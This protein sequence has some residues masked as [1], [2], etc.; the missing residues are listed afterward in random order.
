M[1]TYPTL[2]EDIRRVEEGFLKGTRDENLGVYSNIF[3]AKSTVQG[4]DG[5]MATALL[6]SGMQKGLF[7]AAIVVQRKDGYNAEAV[8]AENIDDIMKAKGTKYLR[9]RMM[10]T[11]GELIDKGKRKIAIVGTPCEVRAARRIQQMLLREFPTLQI[12]IIGL[13]CFEAFDYDK[14]KKETQRLLGVSLDDSAKTQIQKGKFTVTVDGKDHSISVREL[15]RAVEKGCAY[16]NDF[17]ARLADISVGSVGSETG[18]S[19]VIVRSDVGQKLLE[20]LD[21]IKG[22]VNKE[23][24]VKLSILK[25]KRAEKSFVPIL[26][27]MPPMQ[28]LQT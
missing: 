9:V 26:Q 5:G 4:Q 27:T 2:E 23:D 10:S 28:T 25:K 13:F 11:L 22:Q 18:Y 12:T 7:D 16:C 8:I 17:S 1:N 3:S 19:T 14:L 15:S 6:I 21:I 20:D 24:V